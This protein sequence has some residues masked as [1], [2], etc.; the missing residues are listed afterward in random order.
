MS[1]NDIK[2]VLENID[3]HIIGWYGLLLPILYEI[4]LLNEKRKDDE[5]IT[6][7][8]KEKMGRL[9][10]YL[11]NA[12]DYLWD[13]AWEASGEST[14]IC[15][16]CGMKGKHISIIGFGRSANYIQRL[17]KKLPFGTRKKRAAYI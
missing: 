3:P 8:V 12:P 6:I 14:N 4:E 15:Q 16:L 7:H 17:N 1:P 9:D 11:D 10:M 13:M 5:K 2:E